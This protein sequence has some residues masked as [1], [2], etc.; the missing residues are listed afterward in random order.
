MF[1]NLDKDS[2]SVNS[3]NDIWFGCYSGECCSIYN[4]ILNTYVA[5][6]A[7]DR[8]QQLSPDL[9]FQ[10]KRWGNW[11]ISKA[12]YH[13]D[14]AVNYFLP[15]PLRLFLRMRITKPPVDVNAAKNDRDR[16]HIYQ[17]FGTLTNLV[18]EIMAESK[19]DLTFEEVINNL[20]EILNGNTSIQASMMG[21]EGDKIEKEVII[22]NML[23]QYGI[24]RLFRNYENFVTDAAGALQVRGKR[25][26]GSK[27]GTRSIRRE[28]DQQE[29]E[30]VQEDV[31][32]EDV[33]QEDVVQED[34]VQEGVV[35]EDVVQEDVVQEDVVQEDVEHR[36]NLKRR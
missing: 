30:V 8:L 19:R 36:E 21:D 12:S 26:L 20:Y 13:K 29:E 27:A 31:V 9:D 28:R 23:L 35:L 15:L 24:N 17:A 10:A 4:G 32:Q 16:R 33:V 3:I 22:S 5:N 34:V 14:K 1:K 7:M 2:G 18:N 6:P 25:T 11:F